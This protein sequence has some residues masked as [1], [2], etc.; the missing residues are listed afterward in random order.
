MEGA[1]AHLTAAELCDQVRGTVI[2]AVPVPMGK[3]GQYHP[4]AQE[5]YS[6]YM[7]GQ[8]VSAVAVWAHTGRGLHLPADQRQAVLRSW[9]NTGLLVVAGVGAHGGAQDPQRAA[10]EMAQE[11]MN[12]G[13]DAL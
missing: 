1:V 6:D 5:R 2:P 12:W 7:R 4:S 11:A 8:E 3:N 9:K 10:L 13:A